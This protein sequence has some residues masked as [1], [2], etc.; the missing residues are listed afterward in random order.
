MQM[1]DIVLVMMEICLLNI[2]VIEAAQFED[3]NEAR[4]REKKI[5]SEDEK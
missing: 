4:E 2:C 5:E 1:I 3:L